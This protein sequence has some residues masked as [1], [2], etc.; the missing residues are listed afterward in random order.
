MIHARGHKRI[1]N[2][3][4]PSYGFT[5]INKQTAITTE[6]DP[7]REITPRTH[8]MKRPAIIS[9]NVRISPFYA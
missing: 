6:M 7:K 3:H 1:P 2:I 9:A 8:A 4:A 5:L